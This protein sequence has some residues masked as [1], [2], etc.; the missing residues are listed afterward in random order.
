MRIGI[1]FGDVIA[2]DGDVFGDGVNNRGA[3]RGAGSTG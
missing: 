2:E 3:R 1:N